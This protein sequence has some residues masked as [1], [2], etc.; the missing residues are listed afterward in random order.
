MAE[1][2][3]LI[4]TNIEADEVDKE[5]ENAL[6][7]L[8][9]SQEDTKKIRSRIKE[10]LGHINL[11]EIIASVSKHPG[12]SSISLDE[13]IKFHSS[14][15]ID[16]HLFAVRIENPV[17]EFKLLRNSQYSRAIIE[18]GQSR[19]ASVSTSEYLE[20]PVRVDNPVASDRLEDY[21]DQ[22]RSNR[23]KE[24]K[25]LSDDKRDNIIDKAA[26]WIFKKVIEKAAKTKKPHPVIDA[27]WPTKVD[28]D[29]SF[30]PGTIEYMER[31]AAQRLMEA[32]RLREEQ[33]N[34]KLEEEES[35]AE[36]EEKK[37]KKEEEEKEKEEKDSTKEDDQD[38]EK[39][40]EEKSTKYDP[41]A[42]RDPFADINI[43]RVNE[44]TEMFRRMAM[45]DDERESEDNAREKYIQELL[46]FLAQG[47]RENQGLDGSIGTCG[48]LPIKFPKKRIPMN[49]NMFMLEK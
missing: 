41:D 16:R 25:L 30:E 29:K 32:D 45:T 35:N 8:D 5:I 31:E 24:D 36:A 42:P 4:P 2:I 37:R 38:E 20:G 40:D 39:T 1:S 48:T 13:A 12:V 7:S 43:D 22:I 10:Q 9:L 27:L 23:D 34:K 49:L 3:V 44:A 28:D 46:M 21:V 26:K 18:Y 17:T 47:A 11:P 15:K 33:I 19:Y 14:N 6:L